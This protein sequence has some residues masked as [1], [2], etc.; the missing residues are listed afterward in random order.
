MTRDGTDAAADASLEGRIAVVT[1]ASRGIGRAI[2]LKLAGAGA[3]VCLVGRHRETLEDSARAAEGGASHVVPTDMTDD[4]EVRA[5][6]AY[7]AR[8][9]GGADILVHNA[10]LYSRGPLADGSI[11][12]LDALY[13]ANV[14]APYLLTQLMLPSLVARRGQIVFVNSSQGLAVTANVGQYGSTQY[15]LRAIA[16]SLRDEVNK[17]GVRV[18]SVFPGRTATPRTERL[19]ETSEQDYRPELLLQPEDIA[20]VIVNALMLPRTAE[21]TNINIRPFVKS[22]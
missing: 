2:A 7:V 17:D 22:Y 6:A 18:L 16:D 21:V 15:A 20:A 19:Y 8:E 10:G 12:Q 13:R 9:L 4:H 3:T 14:R 5:L 1:G 11:D